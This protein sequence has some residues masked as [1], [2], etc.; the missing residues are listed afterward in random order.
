MTAPV[1]R[2]AIPELAQ[3][4]V[5]APHCE[6]GCAATT[7][8]RL[9]VD[10]VRDVVGA[11]WSLEVATRRLTT[12]PQPFLDRTDV[13]VSAQG[14]GWKIA[15][16]E[17]TGVAIE[18]QRERRDVYLAKV[19]N[20]ANRGGA[21]LLVDDSQ[22]PWLDHAAW[23]HGL[24]PH[25]LA[26]WH[27][28]PAAESMTV[29]EGHAWWSGAYELSYAQVLNAAFPDE[30]IHGVAGRFLAFDTTGAVPGPER[31]ARAARSLAAAAR[32]AATAAA[33]TLVTAN[34][35][36][37]VATGATAV[38]LAAEAYSGLHYVCRLA[39]NPGRPAEF[40]R[41]LEFGR[42]TFTRLG[43]EL[44]FAAF[45]RAATGDLLAGLLGAGD[46]V[47]PRVRDIAARW[48]RLWKVAERLAAQPRVTLL[49]DFLREWRSVTS[50]DI[51]L[52][53]QVADRVGT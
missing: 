8:R 39:E 4:L 35:T 46:A 37:T 14:R 50:S 38:D 22:V 10:F 34:G 48:R 53:Q 6:F 32:R 5:A 51:L 44:A 9:G 24:L 23:S 28:D 11:E 42:Y 41:D 3:Y 13:A 52:A 20:A 47:L 16:T 18:D 12:L 15:G 45:A 2:R 40:I 17:I 26:V 29:I 7:M 25:A 21:V 1:V 27:D 19:R 31:L 43:E 33:E 30:D 36:F 49:D